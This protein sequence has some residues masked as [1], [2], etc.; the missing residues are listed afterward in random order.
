MKKQLLL[1][2]SALFLFVTGYSQEISQQQ[3]NQID[4]VNM[5]EKKE[6][7]SNVKNVSNVS[8][9][10]DRKTKKLR[11]LHEK[12]LANSPFKKT[13]QM[14]KSERKAAGIPPNKYLE[15]EWELTMNPQTGTVDIENLRVIRDNLS[16]E[17]AQAI[18][19][20]RTPGDGSDNSWIERGPNN[21]GRS[22]EHTTEL[23]SHHD[24]V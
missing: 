11:K 24:I 6:T 16:R 17:R 13:L 22:E 8:S 3:K 12:H 18:A 1:L 14:S 10:P 2:L 20:G 19:L 23:Q 4:T 5:N 9:K 15:Q 7:N 21:V